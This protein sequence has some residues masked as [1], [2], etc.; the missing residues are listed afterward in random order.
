MDTEFV[1]DALVAAG[2]ARYA[3]DRPDSTSP[4]VWVTTIDGGRVWLGQP[5]VDEYGNLQ[6]RASWF[7]VRYDGRTVIRREEAWDFHSAV[8]EVARQAGIQGSIAADE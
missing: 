8:A 4:A 6:R 2:V 5:A 1:I 3:I 7:W